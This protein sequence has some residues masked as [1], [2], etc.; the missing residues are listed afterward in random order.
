M[1]NPLGNAVKLRPADASDLPL[2]ANWNRQ[3]QEDEGASVMSVAA[4]ESRLSRWLDASY[5]AVIFEN[6]GPVGYALYR[7]T[8]PDLEGA[9]G[10]YLRQF[11]IA[12]EARRTG[13]GS[14]AFGL[15][16]REVIDGRRM[17][18]EV[19]ASNPAGHAFW[20]SL[21]L[22]EYSTAFQLPAR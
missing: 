13:L 19:L 8:D 6:Q 5:E 4:I 16:V 1:S 14:E 3:L 12:R 10:I 17:V 7:P 9:G 15:L 21:H 18:L 20:R 11:F 2:V 22:E